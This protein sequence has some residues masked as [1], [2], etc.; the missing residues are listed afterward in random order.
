VA[1]TAI[2]YGPNGSQIWVSSQG[3]AGGVGSGIAFTVQ[4]QGAALDAGGNLYLESGWVGLVFVTTKFLGNGVIDWIQYDETGGDYSQAYGL[5][6]D[7]STNV[8]ITGKNGLGYPSISYATYKINSTNGNY[9]WT[10]LY[11]SPLIGASSCLGIASDQ[12][13]NCYV[14]GYSPGSNGMNNI[15]TLKYNDDGNQVWLQRYSG[16]NNFG[17]VGN[18]IAVDTNGNVYVAGYEN[19]PQ[20]GTEMVLIKYASEEA[21]LTTNGCFLLDAQGTPGETFNIQASTNLQTWLNLG[22]ITADTN[23]LAQF[24]DSNAF[25]FPHRYY[26]AVPQ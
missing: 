1:L 21:H 9:V 13:N 3:K 10:N 18:A 19:T 4:V 8:L 12:S 14:T 17:A 5:T 22:R 16:T 2:K 25:L 11:P 6:L 24:A 15:V 20:G 23:G 26:M 7:A